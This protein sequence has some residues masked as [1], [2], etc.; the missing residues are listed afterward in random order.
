MFFNPCSFLTTQPLSSTT[1]SKTL[2]T[3]H[4]TTPPP[5]KHHVT[6]GNDKINGTTKYDTLHDPIHIDCGVLPPI[7]HPIKSP[8]NLIQ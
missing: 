3:S 4:S 5:T 7:L 8:S 1:I 2:K 6:I